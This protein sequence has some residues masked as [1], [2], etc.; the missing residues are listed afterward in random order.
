MTNVTIYFIALQTVVEHVVHIYI[1]I[2]IAL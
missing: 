1:Y 2:C